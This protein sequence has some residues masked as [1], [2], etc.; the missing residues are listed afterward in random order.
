VAATGVGRRRPLPW[1]SS[2]DSVARVAACG[3]VQ[4][5]EERWECY[6]RAGSLL[7]ARARADLDEFRR[8]VA[9]ASSWMD[10][11]GAAWR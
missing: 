4:F 2:V 10:L 1:H 3:A 5:L 6:R 8:S 7:A 9:A 11:A